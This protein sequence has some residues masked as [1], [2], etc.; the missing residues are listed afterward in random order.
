[1]WASL[2]FLLYP[3]IISKGFFVSSAYGGGQSVFNYRAKEEL[4]ESLILAQDERWRRA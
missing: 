4:F 3:E 2:S 1:M